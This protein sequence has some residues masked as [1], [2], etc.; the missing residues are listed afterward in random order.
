MIQNQ[1]LWLFGS[2]KKCLVENQWNLNRNKQIYKFNIV[3]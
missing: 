2:T 3:D 1:F